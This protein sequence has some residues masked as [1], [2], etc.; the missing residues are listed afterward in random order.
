MGIRMSRL[1]SKARSALQQRSDASQASSAYILPATCYM[2]IE[3]TL[4][5]FCL[6]R[7]EPFARLLSVW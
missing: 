4:T 3:P 2:A 5:S 7:G 6:A 1:V